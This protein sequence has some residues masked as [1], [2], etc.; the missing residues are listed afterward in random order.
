MPNSPS[1]VVSGLRL[2]CRLCNT[3]TSFSPPLS[4]EEILTSHTVCDKCARD[5]RL[6][7]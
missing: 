1:T 5:L 2:V 4:T 3:Q 6:V 7:R